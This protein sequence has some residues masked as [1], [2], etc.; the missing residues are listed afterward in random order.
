V[1]YLVILVEN[2]GVPF[3]VTMICSQEQKMKN[4]SN[5]PVV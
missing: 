3:S 1:K 5:R 2:G 4:F